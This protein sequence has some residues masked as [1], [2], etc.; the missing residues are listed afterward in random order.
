M[1]FPWQ[2]FETGGSKRSSGQIRPVTRSGRI[3]GPPYSRLHAC[4][5]EQEYDDAIQSFAG[6]MNLEHNDAN[7]PLSIFDGLISMV[8]NFIPF[9]GVVIDIVGGLNK[10]FNAAKSEARTL[11]EFTFANF[12][13]ILLDMDSQLISEVQSAL[14]EFLNEL[15]EMDLPHLE[16]AERYPDNPEYPGQQYPEGNAGKLLRLIEVLE[17][18]MPTRQEL[19]QPMVIAWVDKTASTSDVGEDD[20]VPGSHTGVISITKLV[21]YGNPPGQ[22]QSEWGQIE[23]QKVK[24]PTGVASTLQETFLPTLSLF[25]FPFRIEVTLNVNT[26]TPLGIS[27][28]IKPRNSESELHDA[29][30]GENWLPHSPFEVDQLPDEPPPIADL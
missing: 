26:R 14:L 19:L 8:K 12:K 28:D 24:N 29:D 1:T 21:G 2:S 11:S 7:L 27:N 3:C 17:A 18:R 15:R 25:R 16:P 30:E 5:G 23:V 6:H 9:A 13:D 22:D 20:L 10:I 4:G